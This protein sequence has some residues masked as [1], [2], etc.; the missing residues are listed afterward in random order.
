[1]RRGKGARSGETCGLVKDLGLCSE[2]SKKLG[3]NRQVSDLSRFG[4]IRLSL[5]NHGGALQPGRW[6]RPNWKYE[7]RVKG[8][9]DCQGGQGGKGRSL[10]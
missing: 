2:N 8:G 6:K 10:C 4:F 3:I 1:M 5:P 7:L 9:L